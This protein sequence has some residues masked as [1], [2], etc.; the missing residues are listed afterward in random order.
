M[1][2]ETSNKAVLYLR[3]ANVGQGDPIAEQREQLMQD[4]ANLGL[5]VVGEYVDIGSPGL[6]SQTCPQ[7]QKMLADAR[8]G[9]FTHLFMR[10][11][12]RLSRGSNAWEMIA[13]L[14][15]SGIILHF[16]GVQIPADVTC[17]AVKQLE[18]IGDNVL[19]TSCNNPGLHHA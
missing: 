3:C 5:D 14:R 17:S 10:D 11:I 2:N 9:M 4:A 1:E 6:Q 8:E 18:N 12:S 7:L 13:E 15:E 19:E 16:D